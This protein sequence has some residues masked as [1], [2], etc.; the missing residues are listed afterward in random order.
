MAV[1][2]MFDEL[3]SIERVNLAALQQHPGFTVLE[4]LMMAACKRA[5]EAVIALDPTAEGYERKLRVL[6]SQARDRNE[7]C[8]LVLKTVT[9]QIDYEAEM[10]KQAQASQTTEQP[11]ENPIF[12]SPLR[13]AKE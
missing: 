4:K 6:Q 10:Q 7:F 5:T 9:W 3:S 8:L 12:K 1:P 13:K 2:L 11:P